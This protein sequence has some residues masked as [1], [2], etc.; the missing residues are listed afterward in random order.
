M[1]RPTLL[2]DVKPGA[3]AACEELFGPVVLLHRYADIDT[4]F[5]W[6]NASGFG[7]NF[8]LFTESVKVALH[9]HRTVIAGAVIVNGTSTYR[10]DQMPYG[11]DRSSGY[12]R[13]S[14][15]DTVRAMT[16]ERIVVFQ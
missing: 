16:R 13:E 12:G 7:I 6:A 5:R 14:P 1:V 11:G 3:R 2:A 8:G 15:G 9:A 4:V 10:P